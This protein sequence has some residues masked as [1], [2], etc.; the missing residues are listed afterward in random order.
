MIPR[1]LKMQS[2]IL[3]VSVAAGLQIGTEAFYSIQPGNWGAVVPGM[4]RG[5]ALRMLG[6]PTLETYDLKGQDSWRT[7]SLL[8][9]R[10]LIVRYAPD[11]AVTEVWRTEYWRFGRE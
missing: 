4:A 11:G 6:P 2:L 8:N 10:S 1:R 3:T 9:E 5:L 7:R